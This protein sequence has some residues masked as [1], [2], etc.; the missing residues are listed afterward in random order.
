MRVHALISVCVCVHVYVQL[1]AKARVRCI[2]RFLGL[3][4]GGCV[5]APVCL[6]MH[7]YIYIY[8]RVC[9]QEAMSDG[10]LLPSSPVTE[11]VAPQK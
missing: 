6:C 5:C 8:L 1:N 3:C 2:H 10:C 7:I 4:Q 9:V 11:A